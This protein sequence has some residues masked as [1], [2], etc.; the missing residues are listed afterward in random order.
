VNERPHLHSH[1]GWRRLPLVRVLALG[2]AG[3]VGLAVGVVLVKLWVGLWPSKDKDLPLLGL[4]Y[5]PSSI[6]LTIGLQEGWS[7]VLLHLN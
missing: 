1:Q 7:L 5:C 6:G 3:V 2:P 4:V